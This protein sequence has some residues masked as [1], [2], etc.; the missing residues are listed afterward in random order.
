MKKIYFFTSGGTEANNLAILGVADAYKRSG[1]HIITTSLE[2][3]S[4]KNTFVYLGDN[5]Y[6]LTILP[7]DSR[8]AS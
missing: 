5:E 3:S 4:V 6:E 1:K 7:V 2:H 8:G